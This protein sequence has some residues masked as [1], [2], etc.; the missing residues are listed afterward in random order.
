ME[1]LKGLTASIYRDDYNS[2]I[3]KMK[4]VKNVIIIDDTMPKIFEVDNDY[5]A[6]RIVRRKI[7]GKDYIHAEPFEPGSYAFGGSFI[8]TSDSRFSELS[9]YPIPLHD[10]QMNLE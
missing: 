1:N 9:K 4:D 2:C 3:N 8:Y 7:F 10:R 6:V 5:P